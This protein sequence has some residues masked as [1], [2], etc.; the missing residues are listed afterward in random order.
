MTYLLLASFFKPKLPITNP[1]NSLKLRV[2]PNDLDIN[3]HMNNGRYLTIC[4]LSRVDMF[5]RTGLAKSMYKEDWIPVISEHTMKYKRPL[6]PFQKYEV[7]MEI[8]SWDDKFFQMEHEFIVN[9]KVLA[10]GT[11]SGCVL[12]KSGVIAPDQ[13]MEH[14]TSRLELESSSPSL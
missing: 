2:L 10:E 6:K 8:V 3:M 14:V 13:V 4:D 1:K 7:T 5:I 9:G 11:S 12:S